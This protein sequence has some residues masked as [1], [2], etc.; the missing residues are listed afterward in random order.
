MEVGHSAGE[1]P[2]ELVVRTD[3]EPRDLVAVSPTYGPVVARDPNRPRTWPYETLELQA[4]A[5]G[6]A[7]EEPEGLPG[8]LADLWGK[9]TVQ[10][11]KPFGR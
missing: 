3:P 1:P 8:C 2:V 6:V 5:R 9:L 10:N 11:P 7:V 4:W